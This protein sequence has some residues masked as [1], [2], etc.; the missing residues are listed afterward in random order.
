MKHTTTINTTKK[1]ISVGYV[2]KSHGVKGGLLLFFDDGVQFTDEE[3]EFL[4]IEI[5]GLPVPF[6][7]EYLEERD[8]NLF[9]AEL[10]FLG[11]KESVQTYL[12]CN[13]LFEKKNIIT[14]FSEINIS[15]LEGFLIIDSNMGEIGRVSSIDNFSGNIVFTVMGNKGEYLIPYNEDLLRAF[16][17]EKMIIEMNCPKGI[18]E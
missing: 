11:D 2:K 7:I 9:Y 14:E 8:K 3:V 15:H 4:F 10:G 16:D 12:G 17:A 5:D 13:I 6:P 18:F 1:L